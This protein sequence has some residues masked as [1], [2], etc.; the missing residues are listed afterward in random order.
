M[1]FGLF[2]DVEGVDGDRALAEL[3]VGAGVLGEHQHAVAR[4]DRRGLLGDQVHA[5]EDR[6]DDQQVELLVAGDRLGQVL[7]DPEIDRHPVGRAVA[8]VDDRDQGLDPLE[9]LGVLGHVL[10]GGLQMGDEGDLLAELG[11]VDQERCRTR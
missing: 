3:L 8:V 7:V 11:M 5:V 9:V 2:G 6:V 4:V 10:A 1:A